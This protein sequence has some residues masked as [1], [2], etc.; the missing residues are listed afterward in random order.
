MVV[1]LAMASTRSRSIPRREAWL[2]GVGV[3]AL[4]IGA[5]GASGA[6]APDEA[7]GELMAFLEGDEDGSTDAQRQAHIDRAIA[8][9]P[10]RARYFE[11][12]AMFRFDHADL[13]GAE[14]DLDQAIT[15]DDRAYLRYLR[16]LTLSEL[17]DPSRALADF[18]RAI[19]LQPDNTQFYHGRALARIAVGRAMDALADGDQTVRDA[20]QRGESY[21]ARGAAL[22]ALGRDADAIRDFDEALRRRPDLV[23]PRLARAVSR[24]RLG[25][26]DGARADRAEATRLTPSSH[27]ASLDPYRY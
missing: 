12:R 16:A 22:A 17:G 9:R 20:P 15:L 10:E 1:A 26:E 27:S 8:L 21:F 4:A 2:L 5:I 13:R 6:F 23:Y 25:D 14:S 3:L 19:A 7:D 24:E 11:V 18:D